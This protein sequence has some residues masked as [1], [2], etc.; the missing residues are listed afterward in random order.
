MSK[1]LT[2]LENWK[3]GE[4]QELIS[5]IS[6][7][8]KFPNSKFPTPLE[9]W[10]KIGIDLQISNP[11]GNFDIWEKTGI[12]SPKFPFFSK[13][14]NFQP[15]WKFGEKQDL[16]TIISIFSNPKFKPLSKFWKKQELF[17]KISTFS[18]PN[19]QPLW[20]FGNLGKTGAMISL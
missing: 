14:P 11:F 1:F 2:P 5:K 7:F 16:I 9:I 3:F 6:I 17:S 15:L 10:G 20:K 8:S 18:K 4:K 12:W 19:F 13:S